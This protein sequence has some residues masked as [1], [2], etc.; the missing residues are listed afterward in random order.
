MVNPGKVER[1]VEGATVGRTIS[2]LAGHD[3]MR[4]PIGNREGRPGRQRDLPTNDAI[5]THEVFVNIKQMHGTA[6]SV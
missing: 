1:F 4:I 6:T 5:P 3:F 2:H